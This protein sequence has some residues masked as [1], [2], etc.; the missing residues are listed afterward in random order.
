MPNIR[1]TLLGSAL[2]VALALSAGGAAA[3]PPHVRAAA[4]AAARTFRDWRIA[5]DPGGC[6]AIR[7]VVTAGDGSQ[8][9]EMAAEARPS[10]ATLALRTPLPLFLPDGVALGLGEAPLRA[11]AW[12]TCGEAGCVAEA[13]I[14]AALLADLRRERA[15]QVTLTLED[16]VRIRLG[17]S[18]MGF[19][20]AWEAL[21]APLAATGAAPAAGDAVRPVSRP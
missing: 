1:L 7:A 12:R 18:L 11:I 2:A 13:P 15:A 16:G 14:D 9:L 3:D 21:G 10:G 20:A 4:E 17:V 5:C 6:D 19:A 8:V